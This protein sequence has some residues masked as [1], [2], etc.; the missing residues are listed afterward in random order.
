[1]IVEV[2]LGDLVQAAEVERAGSRKLPILSMT[3]SRGLVRQDT[4]FKKQIA[5][6]DLATYKVVGPNQ[7]IVGIHIDEGALGLARSGQNGIVSPAYSVW[8]LRDGTEVYPP[9]LDRFIRSPRAITYFVAGYRRTAE[10]RGGLTQ[11]RFLALPIPLPSIEE[12]R[13]VAAMLDQADE[14][15][16]ARQQSLAV[17]DCV[18]ES[19]FLAIFGDPVANSMDWDLIALG[20]LGALDR[21]VSKHRP[22]NDPRLLGGAYP[23]IQTGDI[24]NSGGYVRSHTSTYSDIGLRQSKMWPAGTLCITIAANIAKTGILTFDACFPDSVVGF[25]SSDQTTVEY[26]QAVLKFFQKRMEDTAPE[27]AQKN[28]NLRI[29]RGLLVPN[30]PQDLRLMFSKRLRVTRR[31]AEE[32]QASSRQLDSLFDAVQHRAFAGE[33]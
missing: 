28:I 13:R 16:A 27:S 8:D 26:V 25:T 20:D 15:R 12:Q 10:R 33:L 9:Y 3:R 19:I 24:A 21:G 30:P 5:S 23:F 32:M 22:R 31:L 2:P 14:L 29:L 17:L 11:E 7:L 6:R 1:M 18:V 4:V